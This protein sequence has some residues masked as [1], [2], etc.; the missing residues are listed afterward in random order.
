VS[1]AVVAAVA[2]VVV[3]AVASLVMIERNYYLSVVL[4]DFLLAT[5]CWPALIEQIE[6]CLLAVLL[7]LDSSS[8]CCCC[9]SLAKQHYYSLVIVVLAEQHNVELIVEVDVDKTPVVD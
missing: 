5:V 4:H 1:P 7:L 8:T 3:V 9:C 2:V 6:S